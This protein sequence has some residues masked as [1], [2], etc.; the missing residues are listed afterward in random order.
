MSK[1]AHQFAKIDGWVP[2]FAAGTQIDS[3]GKKKDWSEADLDQI[4]SNFD[5]ND[6]APIVVGHPKHDSPAWGWVEELKREGVSLFAKFRDV[7]PEFRAWGKA[8]HIQNRSI[9]ILNSPSG[10]KLGHIG[11]LG[12][13]QPAVAGMERI[14]FSADE[15]ETYEF[16][17]NSGW[18]AAWSLRALA[19]GLRSMRELLV[20]EKGVEAADKAFPIWPI[21][22]AERAAAD[23]E[24]HQQQQ[25]SQGLYSAPDNNESNPVPDPT[26]QFTQADIDRAVA[27]ERAKIDKSNQFAARLAEHR[28]FVSTLVSNDKGEVRL[29]PAQAEGVAEFLA[30]VGAADAQEFTFNAA[31][32]SEQKPKLVD[33]AKKLFSSLPPQMKVGGE[34]AGSS[35]EPN[36][37][38]SHSFNAPQGTTVDPEQAALY[39]K[40]TEYQ[41]KHPGTDWITAVTAVGG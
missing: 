34:R 38:Q 9:K 26:K 3:K 32:G 28:S 10:Y 6:S 14:E 17:V 27:A 29:T 7:A 13:M 23:A 36:K 16:G 30:A 1:S 19:R 41:A 2:V 11:F 25:A 31:D 21:E 20:A 24:A 8:G 5:A 4:V 40:A 33:F 22:D 37:V 39:D 12:A 35:S 18:S 15:G